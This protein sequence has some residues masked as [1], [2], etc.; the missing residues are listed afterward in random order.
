M[1][2]LQVYLQMS[3]QKGKI[4]VQNKCALYVKEL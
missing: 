1:Y 2:M 4:M 3:M